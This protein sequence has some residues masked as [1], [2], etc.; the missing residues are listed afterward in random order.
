MS[1][2]FATASA[3]TPTETPLFRR[4]RWDRPILMCPD[5]V[6]RPFA[7]ASKTGDA[8]EDKS[9]LIDWHGRMVL[10]GA[11]ANPALGTAAVLLSNDD[12]DDKRKLGQL[13][14][15]AFELGGGTRAAEDGTAIHRLI[16]LDE[17][18]K[19]IPSGVPSALLADVDAYRRER[20]RLGWRTLRS[21]TFVA[22]DR[23]GWGG[24]TGRWELGGLAGSFDQ[25]GVLPDAAAKRGFTGLHI[26]DVKTGK[27]H[28]GA[29]SGVGYT[30]QQGT[31]ANGLVYQRGGGRAAYDDVVPGY[32]PINLAWA[33]I[34][35]VPL[36]RAE[37]HLLPVDLSGWKGMVDQADAV[38]RIRK[39]KGL[40]GDA[41]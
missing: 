41:I 11:G 36:G 37:A 24:G 22:Y 14:R 25:L 32:G 19:T 23:V 3:P 13:E 28:P 21:E 33:F 6:E 20:D 4:D 30:C 34:W 29:Y 9:S 8:L 39:R 31:Y 27:H 7:R 26:A 17:A 15:Q 12:A 38:L 40:I 35:W 16:E 2:D 1:F 10:R 18:G 5:G